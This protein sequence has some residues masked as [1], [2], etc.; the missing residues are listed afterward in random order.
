MATIRTCSRVSLVS[1]L[2]GVALLGACDNGVPP[3]GHDELALERGGIDVEREPRRVCAAERAALERQV[4]AAFDVATADATITTDPDATL[5]L[6]AAD[7]RRFTHSHG[8]STATTSYESAST[9]KL[10]T[11]IVILDLV[12]Q[13]ALSLDST[14]HELIPFWTGETAITLRDLLSFRS[15]FD[16]EPPR[17]GDEP[18]CIDNPAG[19]FEECVK[20]IYRTNLGT[21]ARPGT[22][23]DYGSTHMQIA[24]L[25]AMNATGKTWSEIF[26]EWKTATGLFPTGVYNLPSMTNPRLAG[27]MHWTGEEYLAL[28]RGLQQG[29]VLT[30][31]SRAELFA[32]QRGGARVRYSP[33]LVALDEDWSYGLGNWLEC[34]TAMGAGTFDCGAGHRN[35]SPGAYG[36]Y[37][38][39]DFDHHYVGV[40]A[41]QGANGTFRDGLAIFHE[42]QELA[43]AW[44]DHR[45]RP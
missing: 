9:S 11:A 21:A 16:E 18:P 37:P 36:A 3:D 19:N 43:T 28:L 45:C 17:I 23:F 4:A 25:M 7:G 40:L 38:F 29:T 5:L 12:D 6:Q 8:A 34:P 24:G 10:V 41:R 26:A 22:R 42:V 35:S 20:K 33:I 32:D 31:A 15:G 39:I 30:P 1:S 14:A 2:L 27:G 13:G 44:A